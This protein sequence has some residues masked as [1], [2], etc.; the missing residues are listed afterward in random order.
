MHHIYLMED[1]YYL[2]KIEKH[3]IHKTP[4]M[5]SLVT[6]RIMNHFFRIMIK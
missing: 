1:K 2:L 3:E 5:N 6:K 4:G